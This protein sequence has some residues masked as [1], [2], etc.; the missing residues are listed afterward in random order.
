MTK[1]FGLNGSK[2]D[3][4]RNIKLTCGVICNHI[5]NFRGIY[6][7]QTLV[8]LSSVQTSFRFSTAW[9]RRP[10]QQ[11]YLLSIRV[12]DNAAARFIFRNCG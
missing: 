3:K 9:S 8:V 1:D 11:N 5:R 7:V 2:E 4:Q 10:S 12:S 6:E